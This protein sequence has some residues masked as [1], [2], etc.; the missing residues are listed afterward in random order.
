MVVNGRGIGHR[1]NVYLYTVHNAETGSS[2]Y[3]FEYFEFTKWI[4]I[5]DSIVPNFS[6][7]FS[8]LQLLVSLLRKP[9]QVRLT[10][11]KHYGIHLNRCSLVV[12]V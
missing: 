11:L 12:V 5:Y 7:N 10:F 6:K 2:L 4:D 3:L 9:W 1:D 8:S